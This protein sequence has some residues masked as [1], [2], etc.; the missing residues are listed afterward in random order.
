MNKVLSTFVGPK[1]GPMQGSCVL[2][3][4]WRLDL[5]YCGKTPEL[6]AITRVHGVAPEGTLALLPTCQWK[7]AKCCL[8]KVHEHWT[9]HCHL[10][11]C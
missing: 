2:G 5:E 4:K 11:L 8:G 3:G 1:D 7:A 6:S 9:K 10:G